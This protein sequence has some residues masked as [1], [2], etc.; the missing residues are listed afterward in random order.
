MGEESA[1]GRVND[2]WVGTRSS[3]KLGF[4][5][6]WACFG[7]RHNTTQQLTMYQNSYDAKEGHSDPT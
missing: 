6:A 2:R 4:F 1:A 3:S 5:G 7:H